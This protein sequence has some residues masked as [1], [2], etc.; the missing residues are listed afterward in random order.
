MTRIEKHE[1]AWI[2]SALGGYPAWSHL[3]HVRHFGDTAWL[4]S[5]DTYNLHAHRLGHKDAVPEM[6]VDVRLLMA[7]MAW[8]KSTTV[9]WRDGSWVIV[10]KKKHVEEVAY[11][12]D[13]YAREFKGTLPDFARVVPSDP[14]PL[15]SEFAINWKRFKMACNR[16]MS[17]RVVLRMDKPSA[18]LLITPANLPPWGSIWFA[19]VM[20]MAMEHGGRP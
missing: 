17:C 3:A 1:L 20:P 7:D 6:A 16:D 19:V 11:F 10:E 14:K 18:P 4:I 12:S 5:C 2:K 8:H 9:M 15:D 13:R